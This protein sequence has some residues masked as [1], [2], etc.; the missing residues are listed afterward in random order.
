MSVAPNGDFVVVW[1]SIGSYGT[2]TS[3][4]SKQGQRYAS[5]GSAIGSEFQANT[6]TTQSQGS[7]LGP[8]VSSA[9][10]GDFVVHRPRVSLDT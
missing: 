8:T 1:T 5:D 10:N 6:Y 4:S 7:R 3:G 9:A 2:D